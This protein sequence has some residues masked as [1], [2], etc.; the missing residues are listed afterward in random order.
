MLLISRFESRGWV[1]CWT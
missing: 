1:L